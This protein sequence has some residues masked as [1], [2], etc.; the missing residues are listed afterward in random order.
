MSQYFQVETVQIESEGGFIIINRS[1]FDPAVHKLYEAPA[2]PEPEPEP[3]PESEPEPEPPT[4]EAVAEMT[5]D[6]LLETGK[7]LG[8]ALD[9]RLG[10]SKLRAALVDHLSAS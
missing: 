10:E 9:G 4:V 8:L 3:E 2:E 1:D 7:Q 6:Q 5:R